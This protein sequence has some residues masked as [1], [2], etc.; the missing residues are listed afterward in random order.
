MLLLEPSTPTQHDSIPSN[1][2]HFRSLGCQLHVSKSSPK[3][4][5]TLRSGR[6][7]LL[8]LSPFFA[9]N[10]PLSPRNAWYSGYILT[11]QKLWDFNFLQGLALGL[12]DG[13][14]IGRYEKKREIFDLF[15]V[16][17]ESRAMRFSGGK[18]LRRG[19]LSK[20]GFFPCPSI[21][22]NSK[23]RTQNPFNRSKNR[24][25]VKRTTIY[26]K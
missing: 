14:S 13:F 18:S 8:H 23:R 24:F 15:A 11:V 19:A 25:W 22:R 21:I 5:L 16:K 20:Q 1:P 4:N 7:S 26:H 9:S 2:S 3:I 12:L 17:F 10:F 6:V